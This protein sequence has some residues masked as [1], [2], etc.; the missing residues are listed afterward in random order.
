MASDPHS[1]GSRRRVEGDISGMSDST[2]WTKRNVL[3]DSNEVALSSADDITFL[4]LIFCYVEQ[5]TLESAKRL[6]LL[7][8]HS[9]SFDHVSI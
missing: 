8:W 6:V 1:S 3:S 9:S 4:L 2:V 7:S 5:K